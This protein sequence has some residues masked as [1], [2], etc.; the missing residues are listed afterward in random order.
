MFARTA[1]L[2][3]LAFALVLSPSPAMRGEEPPQEPL[4]VGV[5]AAVE[6]R[7]LDLD[8]VATKDGRPVTDLTRDEFVV[9]IDKKVVPIDYFARVE[10]GTVHGPDLATASPDLVLDT[11]RNDAGETYVPRQFLVYFDDERLLPQ[12]RK[13]VLEGL[14][15]FVMRL[16]PSDRASIVSYNGATR[17]LVPFT[18]SKEDLLGGL[19][20]LEA[21]APRGLA[22]ESE[23]QRTVREI[24]ISPRSRASLI[25]NWSTEAAHRER[26]ALRELARSVSALAARSGKRTLLL[27]T[28]GY[29]WHPGRALAL[30]YG[31]R[32]VSQFAED[33][34]E[35]I[36]KVLAE[37]NGA[38]ITIQVFDAKGLGAGAD[39]SERSNPAISPFYRAQG[40]RDSMVTLATG[41]GG[42]LV[43]NRNEFRA[44]LDRVYRES[45]G[46]YSV[47]VTL[48][49]L[50]G[51]GERKVEVRTTRPGVVVRARTH[52][53]PRSADE[54]AVDRIEMAL[55]TPGVQGDFPAALRIGSLSPAGGL[56]RRTGP[57][58]VE[59]SLA[60]L[61]FRDEGDRKTAVVEITL[62]AIQDTGARSDVTP[63]KKTLSIPVSE[64]E[65]AS[66]Q[67]FVYRGQ[68]KSGKGN[69]RFVAGV[70]DV[71]TGRMAL[72]S[73]DVRVD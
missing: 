20:K 12:D 8:V 7:A 55:L 30:A 22:L 62:A 35:E 50:A 31:P 34:G 25:R 49:G 56:A 33:V 70:R 17:V 14:R 15:D 54:A 16:S 28:N 69:I 51:A 68:V 21:V 57:Y 24:R 27:V 5:R 61:T 32:L 2:A 60:D 6:V 42:T 38:G 64:W 53:V 73:A 47:G 48:A 58:E 39:A 41:T 4:P 18:S 40:F 67:P 63:E 3:L 1:S 72:A 19:S 59:F 13:P 65:R 66:S 23:Y 45:S 26:W 52:F 71:A 10:A 37:A 44:D 43:E 46:Y 29:E 9:R 36:E 11:L